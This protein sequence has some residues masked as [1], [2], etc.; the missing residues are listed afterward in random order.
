MGTKGPVTLRW[1]GDRVAHEEE[2]FEDLDAALDAVVARWAEIGDRA[3]QILD[4]RRVLAV[5]TAELV[6]IAEEELAQPKEG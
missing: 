4:M 5:S 2:R 1:R 3:P 6:A